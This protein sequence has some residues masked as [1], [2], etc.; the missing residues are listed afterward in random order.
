V[1]ELTESIALGA[2]HFTTRHALRALDAIHLASASA[3]G[4]DVVVATWD[5]ELRRAAAEAGLAVAPA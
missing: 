2:A 1:V 4:E 5:D 3:L